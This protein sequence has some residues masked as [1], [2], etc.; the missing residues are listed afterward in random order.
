[1]SLPAQIAVSFDFSGGATFGSG[2]VI[3]SPDNGVIGV[4]S[5]G[6]SDVIIPTVDLTPDV[7]SI[8]I[9]R[10]RNVMKDTYDAGTAIVRVLDPLGYFNPQNP[11]SPYYGYLVPLR[12][13]RISATTA[14]AEH[15]LFSGYVNDYRYTFPVGQETAYVDIMCT[16][17]FRLLQMSNVGTIPDTAAG[18]DTGTRINKILDNVSFPASMRSISTGVSTCV[19]DPATNRSTLDAIKN[20]EFSEG[21]GAFY[22][23]SDGTAVYL[24]RTE[25]TS[26]L[27][28]PSIAFNQTTGIPYKNVKYAF[29]DKLI[30]NDVKFNRVGGTAQ[31]VY[32]QSSIDKYFPHSLTQENLVAQTD[33]IVLG[34]AQNYVN[35]RKETTIRIDEMLVDLLDPAV[36]TDTLIGLDYFDNLDITNVTESGSTIQKVLQAQGFAWDIT[37]NKM[38]VA[39]TTLEPIVD[40]FIIGSTIFGIIGTSTL[41]Y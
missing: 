25:V 37:A 28:E 9:R 13:L 40:G 18:Q 16:D 34:I 27:G 2:F 1:M 11:A 8:S 12:K 32:S 17:G 29:D 26:S 33:D 6:S 5:F 38:Q 39:I 36:P 4:N 14:T 22:M 23:S 10:G 7:Y 30:I 35:T 20:A 3:G 41:S 19:A 31:L 24:N 15:F 21:L